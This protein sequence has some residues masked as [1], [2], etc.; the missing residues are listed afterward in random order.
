MPATVRYDDQYCPIARALDVLGDRW[1]LLVLR[2]LLRG[3]Q[4]FTDLRTH[5]PGIAPGVLSARLTTLQ[6]QGLIVATD[7]GTARPKYSITPRGREA[8]SVMRALA[9]F[10]MPLLEDPTE[11]DVV[12]PWSAVQTC[13]LAY[14]DAHAA[15]GTDDHYLFRVDGQ[16]FVLSTARGAAPEASA[17]VLEVDTTAATLFAIRK[18]LV[19]VDDAIAAGDLTVHGP[20]AALRRLRNIYRLDT[21]G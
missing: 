7:A 5:L 16:E 10:G 4:R 13:L 14:W 3:E 2:E 9:R 1:T 15:E 18:G 8:Q 21:V 20:R 11:V 19:G 17:P 12:R 6:E